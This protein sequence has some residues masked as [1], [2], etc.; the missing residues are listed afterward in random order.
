MSNR[1]EDL[2]I[3][4]GLSIWFTILCGGF[5]YLYWS[6]GFVD[7]RD[8]FGSTLSNIGAI[9]VFPVGWLGLLAW[10]WENA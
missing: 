7:P 1:A 5:A 8:I 4:I 10:A 6:V 2:V 9:M 3:A